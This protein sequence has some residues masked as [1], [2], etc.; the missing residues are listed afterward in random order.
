MSWKERRIIQTGRKIAVSI[1]SGIHKCVGVRQRYRERGTTEEKEN[2]QEHF[3]NLRG[4]FDQRVE[5][6]ANTSGRLTWKI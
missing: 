5:H 1:P 4:N 2:S 3:R 6:H